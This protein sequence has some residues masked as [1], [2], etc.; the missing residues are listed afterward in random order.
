MELGWMKNP[1]LLGHSPDCECA[2]CIRAGGSLSRTDA[3]KITVKLTREEKD[4][5]DALC[6]AQGTTMSQA[7]RAYIR[8]Q[9]ERP[10]K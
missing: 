1:P 10:R 7:L 9:I 6:R 4:A 5:F 2:V 3:Q 8:Q